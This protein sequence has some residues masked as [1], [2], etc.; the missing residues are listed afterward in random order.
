MVANIPGF[1]PPDMQLGHRN[2]QVRRAR[3]HDT[4]RLRDVRHPGPAPP[5]IAPVRDS[6]AHHTISIFKYT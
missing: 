5:L 3:R 4:L 1:P 2:P 6:A